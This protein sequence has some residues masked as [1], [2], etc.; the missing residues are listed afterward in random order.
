MLPVVINYPN[1]SMQVT[2]D[3]AVIKLKSVSD[4]VT[5][6]TVGATV[7]SWIHDSIEILFLSKQAVLDG[8]KPIRG[9][10]PIVFPQFGTGD[11]LVNGAGTKQHGFARDKIWE[12]VSVEE[13]RAVLRLRADEETK[14]V[15]PY[16]FEL[17]YRVELREGALY[18]ELKIMALTDLQFTA[19]LHTY[20]R[21]EHIG[22]VL[23]KGFEGLTYKDKLTGQKVKEQ[24]NSI[25]IESEVDRIY[26]NAPPKLSLNLGQH[27]IRV[28]KSESLPDAVLWNPWINK[29]KAMSDFGDEEYKEMVCLEPGCVG[30][31]MQLM[32]GDEWV[33]WQRITVQK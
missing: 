13:E 6:N 17:H 30:E 18:T 3:H 27:Q 7:T 11:I 8:T 32:R 9:G 2:K 1:L 5:I 24:S 33:G 25:S 19:L 16:D 28:E 4:T 26:L 20:F 10:I 21:V 22:D 23:V 12:V 29:S 14:T 31:R 15:Y